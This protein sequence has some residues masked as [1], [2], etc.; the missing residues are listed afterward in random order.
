M[1]TCVFPGQGSQQRGMGQGLFDEV[2]QF[3]P[4]VESEADGILGCSVRETCLRDP[5]GRL[6]QTQYT[7]PCLYV[8][9]ALHYYRA[10]AQ[11]ARPRFL[12]GHSL[13]E[14]DALLAADV[15]DFLEGLRITRKRGELMARAPGGTMAAVIGLA[16]P[17]VVNTL[18]RHSITS[19]DIANYNSPSQ[20]VI[21]GPIADIQSAARILRY[22]GA[23]SYVILSVS[24]A[25]HSRYMAEAAREFE[26]FL[27]GFAFRSPRIPVISNA[28]G[29]PYPSEG[30]GMAIRELLVAQL[31]QPVQWVRTVRYLAG[32]GAT[33]FREVGPGMVLTR[34]IE[35]IQGE[36]PV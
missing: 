9:N 16:A 10:A 12:A 4:E 32:R 33:V 23:R 24:A 30:D 25:C 36:T 35:Q 29:E 22:A 5:H 26:Q 27:Q 6:A 13:G 18:Q 15:F 19:L 8:V 31:T 17:E 3:T 11:G 28:T 14:Y 2:I 7:Q 34:L 1:L 21:S 20:T